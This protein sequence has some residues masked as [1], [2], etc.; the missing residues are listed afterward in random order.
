MNGQSFISD[1][2]MGTAGGTL[3]IFLANINSNDIVKT[4]AMS[5]VGAVIS[6]VVSV[7]LKWLFGKAPG[8]P[9]KGK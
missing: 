4:V 3:T 8:E 1:I 7:L 9:K 6:F 5:A 2:R